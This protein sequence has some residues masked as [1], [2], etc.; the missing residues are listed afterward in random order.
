MVIGYLASSPSWWTN[1]GTMLHGL[2]NQ[3]PRGGRGQVE[4][5]ANRAAALTIRMTSI[6]TRPGVHSTGTLTIADA[7]Q[8]RS[9]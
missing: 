1:I 8:A 4:G 7:D 3:K 9:R 6:R 2:R 5:H